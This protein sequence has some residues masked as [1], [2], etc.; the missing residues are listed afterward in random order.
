[1]PSSHRNSIRREVRSIERGLK[2]FQREVGD[3]ITWYEFDPV[4]STPE[5]TYGE[6]PLPNPMDPTQAVVGTGLAFRPPVV[7]PAVWVRFIPPEAIQTDSGEYTINHLSLR[8]AVDSLRRSGLRQSLD[9]AFHYNDR[10]A[11]RD[12]PYRVEEYA[13][14]GWL[15]GAY[16]I[17]DVTGRQLKEE[18]FETDAF[19]M[20]ETA[21]AATYWTPGQ[22]L[23]WQSRQPSDWETQSSDG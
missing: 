17:V 5:D 2:Q 14:K 23:D 19:P 7:I 11:Y 12:F 6:G 18:E 15:G 8:I 20:G 3:V 22:Q 21:Q 13:P 16:L 1:M 10:F 9:P 4:N